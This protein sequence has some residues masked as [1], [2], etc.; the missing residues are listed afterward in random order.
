MSAEKRLSL[1]IQDPRQIYEA[2]TIIEKYSMRFGTGTRSCP[3]QS[4]TH[5]SIYGLVDKITV[6]VNM[7]IDVAQAI[8]SKIIPAM[9]MHF[10]WSFEDPSAER[11]LVSK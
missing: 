9:F 1:G 7:C 10:E 5:F 6:P 2:N 8:M 4:N 11:K 3:G